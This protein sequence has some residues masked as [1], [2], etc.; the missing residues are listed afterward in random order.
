MPVSLRVSELS[1]IQVSELTDSD[2]LLITDTEASASKKLQLSTFKNYLFSGNSFGSFSDVDLS[3]G[4]TDGQFLR[5]DAATQRWNAGDI[6]LS[7][8]G[9]LQDV[10]L[11][12]TAP[13]TGQT[14]IWD[15]S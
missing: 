1:N 6:S 3:S 8:L 9:D 12:S 2:L 14:L 13:Q 10:D 15:G 4:A 5:Y 7:S 11:V